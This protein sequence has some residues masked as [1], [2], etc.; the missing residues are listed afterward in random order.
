MT[1]RLRN[2]VLALVVA[3]GALA[4][5]L[6]FS[7]R[8][9]AARLAATLEPLATLRY[10]SAG[11]T[12]DGAVRLTAP[13]LQIHSGRWLGSITARVVTIRGDGILRSLT[14]AISSERG[15]PDEARIEVRGLDV[16]PAAGTGMVDAWLRPPGAA[17]F[18]MQG[19]PGEALG[20]VE[21][22]RSGVHAAE[23]VD[24]F[25][26]RLD[27]PRGRLELDFNLEQPGVSVVDG[28]LAISA[29]L[30]GRAGFPNEVRLDQGELDY[31]DPG[32]LA[33]RNRVC[34]QRLGVEP[35]QFV[36]RHVAAVDQLLAAHGI[37]AGDSAR[38]LYRR[39]VAEGGTLKLTVLPDATWRPADVFGTPRAELMRVLNA[40][41]RHGS[42]PPIM[43]QLAFTDPAAPWFA[44][45]ATVELS[46]T[47]FSA[48]G[49]S[50]PSTTPSTA[51]SPP[52]GEAATVEASVDAPDR[53]SSPVATAAPVAI[54]AAVAASTAEPAVV[55]TAPAPQPAAPQSPA[56]AQRMGPV[57]DAAPSSEPV[58]FDPRDPARVLGASAPAPPKDSTL[59]LVWK[60]GVIERLGARQAPA[61]DYRII[62]AAE[63]GAH[64]GRRMR[65]LTVGGKLVDGELRGVDGGQALLRVRMASGT[66][67]VAVPLAN[68]R[69]IR[70]VAAAGP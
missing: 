19:C 45:D 43:L 7:A 33:V 37:S 49:D 1:G 10:D 42:S 66:A 70:L 67:D 16:V 9:A 2:V 15:M 3:L 59:A 54:P 63:I 48:A 24:R 40:T 52:P 12:W 60:P 65:L 13:Q 61:R 27:A 8:R 39:L 17:L 26:Y 20:V 4:L 41:A 31:R 62:A 35:A 64:R 53:T 23:R 34:A 36:E 18:E 46:S 47:A 55:D 58:A 29:F 56:V 50:R 57:A 21:R 32:Y 25:D 30:P 28:S 11:T 22:E 44:G 68:V 69:E 51:P 6:E 14:R 5:A 38:A